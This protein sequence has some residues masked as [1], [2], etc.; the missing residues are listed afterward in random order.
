[1]T[2]GAQ[3]MS[4]SSIKPMPPTVPAGM[5]QNTRPSPAAPRPAPV[6]GSSR[7]GA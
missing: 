4:R 6:A 1:M 7:S 5:R 2:A 3:P